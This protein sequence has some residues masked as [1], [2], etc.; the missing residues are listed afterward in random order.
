MMF[1][2]ESLPMEHPEKLQSLW[3]SLDAA[4]AILHNAKDCYP[5]LQTPGRALRRIARTVRRP[6][7]VAILGESNSG[8]SSL[9]NLMVGGL[10][11]P[12]PPVANTRL[13]TLLQYAPVPFI[14]A[15]NASG[16]RLALSPKDDALP[17]NVIRLEVGLPSQTLRWLEVLDFPGGENPLL[18]TTTPSML[19]HGIDA[20]IWTT[21]A[22][23]AWRRSERLAWLALPTRIRSRGLLTVTHCDLIP[24]EED[25]RRLSARLETEAKPHFW[26]MCFVAAPGGR[27]AGFAQ[28]MDT[29]DLFSQIG[30]LQNQF[31]ADRL[32]RAV[33]V[34]RRLAG[35]TLDRLGLTADCS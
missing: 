5:V 20:A 27:Q 28:P 35:Q 15:V 23:Q 32:E 6:M 11:L 29:S 1:S 7:R 19:R 13:P 17:E 2:Q 18:P 33:T 10:T 4:Q 8:K 3:R 34:T 14:R 25:L 12:A 22:T 31:L 16:V 26:G 9:A 24:R 21:V 30:K